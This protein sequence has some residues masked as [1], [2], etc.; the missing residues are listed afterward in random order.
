MLRAFT[1]QI[2]LLDKLEKK[3]KNYYLLSFEKKNIYYEINSYFFMRPFF[4]NER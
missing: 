1:K 3:Q 4:K 2:S